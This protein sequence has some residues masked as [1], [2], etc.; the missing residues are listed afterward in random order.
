VNRQGHPETLRASQAGNSNALTHGAFSRQTLAPRAR[1]LADALLQA[2]HTVP[3]DRLGAEEIGAVIAI[4]ER[5]DEEL[6]ANG[7]TDRKGNAR[8][9]VELRVRLSGR[10]ERWL[11]AYGATPAARVQWVHALTDGKSL[12]DVV[13]REVAEGALLLEAAR[14]RGDF[15][16]I[17][18][19]EVG[20]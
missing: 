11:A 8:S 13:R 6:L 4:L 10:L 18:P 2:P 3:L 14:D 12:A 19:E 1:E 15:H 7:L 5:I 16:P 20:S 9:L 17:E